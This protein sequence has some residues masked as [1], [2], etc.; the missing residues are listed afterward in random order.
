MVDLQDAVREH[1]ALYN[2]AVHLGAYRRLM[3]NFAPDA[4][5]IIG[6]ERYVGR[7]A[8]AAGEL[9]VLRESVEVVSVEQSS[10]EHAHVI[11]KLDHAGRTGS[12]EMTWRDGELVEVSVSYA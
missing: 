5:L 7:D 12:A 9:A 3:D 6:S 11:F 10:P 1:F 2:D 4:V 8:I